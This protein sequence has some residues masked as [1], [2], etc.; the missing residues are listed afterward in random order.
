MVQ[1]C[2]PSTEEIEMDGDGVASLQ[3]K[4]KPCLKKQRGECLGNDTRG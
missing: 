2:N 3:G 1:V 4:L